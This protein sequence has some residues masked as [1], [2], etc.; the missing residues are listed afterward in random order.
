MENII[1]VKELSKKYRI[2]TKNKTLLG[3]IISKLSGRE[4]KKDIWALN[5]VSFEVKEGEIIGLIGRNGSGKTTLLRIISGIERATSG[6]VIVEGKS[7]PI[8]NLN[9]GLRP[10]LSLKENVFYSC[11]LLGLNNR[12]TKRI[13]PEILSFSGLE[14]FEDTKLYQFSM[15]MIARLA[16]SILINS[17]KIINPK[18]ILLDEIFSYGDKELREKG[19]DAV[20]S[21]A[22]KG[23]SIIL[24]SHNLEIIK[25][26]CK[27]TIWIESGEIKKIG[28][29]EKIAKDYYR[30]KR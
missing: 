22:K 15:G 3:R 5:D 17:A 2:G 27:R 1:I 13:Y 26:A 4:S 25:N 30:F 9:L 11:L 23:A 16:F 8:F 12:E 7:M 24:V 19:M 21:M 10:R 29:T 14:N 28:K 18:I 20:K 6:E